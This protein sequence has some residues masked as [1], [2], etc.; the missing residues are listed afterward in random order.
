MFPKFSV[1]LISCK[2]PRQSIIEKVSVSR[3]RLV[4]VL[5]VVTWQCVALGDC[6]DFSWVGPIEQDGKELCGWDITSCERGDI[7]WIL[8]RL[9]KTLFT[10]RQ[11]GRPNKRQNRNFKKKKILWSNVPYLGSTPRHTDWLTVSRNVTLTL[12]LSEK[13][14]FYA[15]QVVRVLG[16]RSGGPGYIPSTKKTK[17]HGLSPR[18]NYTDRATAACRRTDCQLSRIEDATWSVW[19]IPT[20]VFSVF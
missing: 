15:F 9:N 5:S 10:S 8:V 16:Y 7:S 6:I 1:Y 14:C 17:L 19:R 11:R 4:N 18:A 2:Q 13:S 20:A 3:K 12:T